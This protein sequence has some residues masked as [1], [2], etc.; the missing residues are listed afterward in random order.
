MKVEEALKGI[1]GGETKMFSFK[2]G[3]LVLGASSPQEA[4]DL[5]LKSRQ[6]KKEINEAL[7]SR[8]VEKIR[9]RV[10]ID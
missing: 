5:F 3:K 8:V 6:I 9:Y 7:G 2:E 4:N 1:M 10:K